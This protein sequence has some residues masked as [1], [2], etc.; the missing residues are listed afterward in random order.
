MPN[1]AQSLE[2]VIARRGW[3]VP[4]QILLWA[5]RFAAVDEAV[6]ACPFA[7]WVAA[8]EALRDARGTRVIGAAARVVQAC[9]VAEA[10]STEPRVAAA[11]HALRRGEP[12]AR[13]GGDAAWQ[14][15]PLVPEAPLRSS[16]HGAARAAVR[17]LAEAARAYAEQDALGPPARLMSA[18]SAAAL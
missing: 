18:I 17:L 11:L 16:A 14:M 8:L 3:L 2:R 6:A 7:H 1:A 15:V 12:R 4:D 9:G 5:G 13:G 10:A